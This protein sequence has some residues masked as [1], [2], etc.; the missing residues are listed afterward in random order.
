MG[1]RQSLC[2][3]LIVACAATAPAAQQPVESDQDALVRLEQGWNAAF[4]KKDVA[5]IR[6]LL[7][8]EFIATY[9]DGSRGD[10]TK[11]LALVTAFNQA[12]ES[13]TPDQF[14]VKIYRDSAVVWFTLHLVGI[15]EGQRSEMTLQYTDV[16]LVRDGR[17]QCVS[18]QSTRVNRGQG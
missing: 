14:I 1:V 15:R 13:A 3:I 18:S 7:A 12:V 17:W 10:K 9:D 5:F 6:N 2:G 16:W 11:E 4:Y 8:D